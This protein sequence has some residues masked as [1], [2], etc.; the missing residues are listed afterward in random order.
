MRMAVVKILCVE[1]TKFSPLSFSLFV[2][3]TKVYAV[4]VMDKTIFL[5]YYDMQKKRSEYV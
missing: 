2:K 4:S 1:H 5:Y 3:N